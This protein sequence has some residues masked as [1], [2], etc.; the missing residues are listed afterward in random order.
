[1]SRHRL[2]VPMAAA[3]MALIDLVAVGIAFLAVFSLRLALGERGIIFQ[4]LAHGLDTYTAYWP[5]ALLWPFILWREGVYPGLWMTADEE[6][7]RTVQGSTVAGMLVI[8]L[9]FVTRTGQEFSR[10]ILAG[11]WMLTVIL[12]PLHHL[13]TKL[14]FSTFNL[15]S[16]PAVIL[17][18]NALT[19]RILEGI[20]KQELPPLR[21]VALFAG[22]GE[23][24]SPDDFDIPIEGSIAEAAAWA[25]ERKVET[26]VVILPQGSSRQVVQLVETLST[27]F[28]RILVI[29]DLFGMSTV[30]TDVRDLDGVLA[31]EVRRNLLSWQSQLAKRL[32]D[33]LLSLVAG[34]LSLPLWLVISLA[35]WMERQGPIFYGHE[36]VGQGGRTFTA[37]KFRTMVR[38]A[39]QVLDRAL[40][41]DPALEAEWNQTQKL[42][43]DPRLTSVGR[44]L[45]R[46]SLDELPQL[47]NILRQE[48]SLVGPRPIIRE[49]I[50][51]YGQAFELYTQVRPGLTGLWQ[52]SGR[53]NLTYDERV[54]LDAYYVRNWSVWLDIVI[55]LRTFL[56]VLT[57]RGAY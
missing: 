21:P 56:A 32:L 28:R 24:P 10:P 14:V 31:L 51:K 15:G 34:L 42:R 12:I 16:I 2:P 13:G 57:G 18:T 52:V 3:M 20:R 35:L 8:L 27:S 37:W 36:R 26:A 4:P 25:Q 39:D 43:A 30:G 17:G 41:T 23:T 6:L 19:Q 50:H 54:R 11:W 44:A 53:S 45:R 9:T 38:D 33:A 46:L 1:V 22:D 7:R 48:M 29:P 55:I 47:W 49:E 5:I 40:S